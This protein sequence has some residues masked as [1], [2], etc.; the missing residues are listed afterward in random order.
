[1]I[2]DVASDTAALI[3]IFAALAPTLSHLTLRMIFSDDDWS[4]IV[5]VSEALA[6]AIATCQQLRSLSIGGHITE[7]VYGEVYK[8]SNLE[9][10]VFLPACFHFNE[11]ELRDELRLPKSLRTVTYASYSGFE[12]EPETAVWY[13][14]LCDA[15]ESVGATFRDEKRPKEVEWLTGYGGGA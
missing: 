15:C 9:H 4:D 2:D 5:A 10:L 3:A 13:A 7:A 1:M 8:L 11:Y 6:P 12:F 14:S